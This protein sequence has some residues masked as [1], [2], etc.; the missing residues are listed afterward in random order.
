MDYLRL[1]TLIIRKRLT[2]INHILVIRMKN[3]YFMIGLAAASVAGASCSSGSYTVTDVA[4]TRILVDSVYDA[5]PD[6][7]AQAFLA[8]YSKVVDSI[9]SPVMGRAARYMEAERPESP[10]SNLLADILVWAGKNYGEKPVMGLYN[11]G[12]IRAALP[13]GDVTYGHV[14]EVAPFENKIC[15]L[16][17]SGESL[18]RL[19]GSIAATGGEGVSHGV[20]MVIGKD[21]HGVR[22][23]KGVRLHGREIDPKASYRIATIDYLAQGNDNMREL[24]EGTDVNSPQDKSND[25]RY[26]ISGYFK[27]MAAQGKVVDSKNEGRIVVE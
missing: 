22:M 4:R 23:L 19:F 9:M 16:T 12:G 11:M 8:P 17:L 21:I 27:E 24:R 13:A 3:L 10:L 15:F 14:L 6:S 25:T 26:I 2:N 5:R 20:E 1:C 7:A 18:L